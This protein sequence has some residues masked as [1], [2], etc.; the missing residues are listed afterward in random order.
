M[1][2]SAQHI[3]EA[4]RSV[5]GDEPAELH[6]P[7]I[8]GQEQEF[9]KQCI[10]SGML[11]AGHWVDEFEQMLCKITGAKYAIA[12]VNGTCALHAALVC[13]GLTSGTIKIPALTFVGTASAVIM[14]GMRPHF[15]EP[16]NANIPVD[17]NGVESAAKGIVRDSAQSFGIPLKGTRIYSFNQNKVIACIG[18]AVV[19]D[20]NKLSDMIR[21]YV[22]T[23]RI[24]HEYKVEHDIVATNYRMPDLCAAVGLG[25][26]MNFHKIQEAKSVLHERYRAAF[27]LL[28]IK[29]WPGNWLNSILV[30]NRDEV[31]DA[32][33]ASGYKARC[34]PTP[35][36]MLKPYRNCP[37]DDLSKSMSVW[38]HVVQ[39]PS[40][41]KLGMR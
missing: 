27:A 30:D 40:S 28:G 31:I 20:D 35:L 36:H 17:L 9:A 24:P 13:S 37:Y 29:M 41:P 3:I 2:I 4:V 6:Q 1:A 38:R 33:L 15:V 5:I 26:L 23:G 21:H 10:G 19:T 39:L 32:L 25:Q 12:T 11:G 18:G 14:A 22:T 7:Y 8:G 34:L 16:E